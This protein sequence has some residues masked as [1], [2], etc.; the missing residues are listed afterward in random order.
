LHLARRKIILFPLVG[1]I[2]FGT[3]EYY[4]I[5]CQFSGLDIDSR[6]WFF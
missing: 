2:T 5:H 3:C 6:D 1:S 4:I